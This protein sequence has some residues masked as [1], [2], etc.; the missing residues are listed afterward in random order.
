V[1]KDES[2]EEGISSSKVN[3]YLFAPGATGT[4]VKQLA[5]TRSEGISDA[6][7]AEVADWLYNESASL[8]REITVATS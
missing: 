3:A 5:V 6:D 7:F 4:E 2:E 8:A 1:I